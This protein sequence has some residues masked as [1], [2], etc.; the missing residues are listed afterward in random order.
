MNALFWFLCGAYALGLLVFG[1]VSCEF[2]SEERGHFNAVVLSVA[3]TVVWP[4]V[5]AVLAVTIAFET[6]RDAVRKP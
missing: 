4:L 6:L 3:M 5:A 2:I 1:W